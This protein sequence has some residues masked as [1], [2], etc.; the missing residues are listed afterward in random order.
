MRASEGSQAYPA[1]CFVWHLFC[2]PAASSQLNLRPGFEQ[3]WI[4]WPSK[5]GRQIS[6]IGTMW[7]NFEKPE[8]SS[9]SRSC[10]RL[11]LSGAQ[12]LYSLRP[13]WNLFLKLSK[14]LLEKEPR[15]KVQ[16]LQRAVGVRELCWGPSLAVRIHLLSTASNEEL[17]CFLK[18]LPDF[19]EMLW[20][21]PGNVSIGRIFL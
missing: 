7:Y 20:E 3:C 4:G 19:L 18:L 14:G 13:I 11:R 6:T 21:E 10:E 5:T 8:N 12:C 17:R 15:F 1:A 2:G 9:N 16:N